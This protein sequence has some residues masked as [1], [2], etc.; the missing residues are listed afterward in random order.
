[1]R[2]NIVSGRQLTGGD[3][4]T[5]YDKDWGVSGH[6]RDLSQNDRLLKF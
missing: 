1:M 6:S 3:L 4:P 2:G 5:C